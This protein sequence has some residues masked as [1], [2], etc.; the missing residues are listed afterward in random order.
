MISLILLESRFLKK[1][2]V[3]SVK[4]VPLHSNKNYCKM[5]EK[6]QLS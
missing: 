6:L 2:T 4:K 3:I 1:Y 5:S